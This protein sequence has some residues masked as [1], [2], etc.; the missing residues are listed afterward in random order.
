MYIEDL[1]PWLAEPPNPHLFAVGWLA[2]G[3][4]FAT[5]SCDRVFYRKLMELLQDP[6]QPAVSPGRHPCAFCQFTGGPAVVRFE[7]LSVTIGTGVLFVPSDENVYVTPTMV[8]HYIDSHGYRPPE[9]FM[10]AVATCAP[11]RSI[12]YFRALKSY[13]IGPTHGVG[14][15]R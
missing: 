15:Q 8:A 13:G 7:E 4:M 1:K 3:H 5:G 10:S 12:Q 6:W 9:E 14:G 11:M 2:P